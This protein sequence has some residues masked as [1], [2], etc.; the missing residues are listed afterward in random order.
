MTKAWRVDLLT[1]ASN[2][3]GED[4][5]GQLPLAQRYPSPLCEGVL[6]Y[7]PAADGTGSLAG[8]APA[9]C[10]DDAARMAH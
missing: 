7:T 2:R 9:V 3:P 5:L 4:S 1:D 10:I 8:R 6:S